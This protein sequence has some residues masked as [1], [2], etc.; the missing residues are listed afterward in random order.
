MGKPQSQN[1]RRLFRK[2]DESCQNSD[3]IGEQRP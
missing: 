1:S 3:E 2:I